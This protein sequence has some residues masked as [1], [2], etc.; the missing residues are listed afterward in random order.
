[1]VN[2]NTKETIVSSEKNKIID[3]RFSLEIN[4]VGKRNSYEY[5]FKVR[6][7]NGFNEISN[8]GAI[9]E[10]DELIATSRLYD[11]FHKLVSSFKDVAICPIDRRKLSCSQ[12]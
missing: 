6:R 7:G 5:T 8:I 9:Y 12:K 2:Q 4:H 11:V 10:T 3:G 1:M